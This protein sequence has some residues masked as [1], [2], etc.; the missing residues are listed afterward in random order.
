MLSTSEKYTFSSAALYNNFA[1]TVI[2]G[3][4]RSGKTSLGNLLGTCDAVENAEEPWT[5][6]LIPLTH[7]L[8]ML[9][10]KKIALEMFVAYVTELFNDMI[11]LRRASFRPDDLSY[12]FLQKSKEEVDHRLNKILS[13]QDV[14]NFSKEKQSNLLLNLTEVVPFLGFIAEALPQAKFLYLNRFGK[15]VAFDCLKKKWFSDEQLLTPIKALPYKFFKYKENT[16]HLPWWIQD[17]DEEMFLRLSE[18]DRCIYYWCSTVEMGFSPLEQ[19]EKTNSCMQI[20]Y[21]KFLNNPN[22]TLARLC[23]YLNIKATPM[24]EM[25]LT[26]I[27]K[28]NNNICTEII[29]DQ[30]LGKKYKSLIERIF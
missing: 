1:V 10:N 24:T 3:P 25:A 26:N 29:K 6:K 7:G 12:I 28:R 4:C 8:G 14:Q 23:D 20:D 2:A 9:S 19:L 11:F 13:R 21:Q 22:K 16:W 27:S 5:A 30:N 18:F 17:G 15:D